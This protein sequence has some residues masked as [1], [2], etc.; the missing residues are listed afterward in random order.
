[1]VNQYSEDTWNLSNDCKEVWKQNLNS[2]INSPKVDQTLH[3][4]ENFCV[5]F[6]WRGLFIS[7][8][9]NL[10]KIKFFVYVH[11]NFLHFQTTGGKLFFRPLISSPPRESSNTWCNPCIV[12][13]IFFILLHHFV[14]V[15][16]SWWLSIL[17]A[18]FIG[19]ISKYLLSIVN[20][21]QASAVDLLFVVI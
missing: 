19:Q 14:H 18:F 17:C 7:F 11:L 10:S 5:F 16:K 1:M 8:L 13:Y 21:T 20:Q 15:Q 12:K 6:C 2:F 3:H 4:E 9:E